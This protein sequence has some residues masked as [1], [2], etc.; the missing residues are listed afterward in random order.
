VREWL[1]LNRD[2]S[3]L[4]KSRR[5]NSNHASSHADGQA[6]DT[7]HLIGA[8]EGAAGVWPPKSRSDAAGRPGDR[9][10]RKRSSLIGWSS[11]GSNQ[12]VLGS[13]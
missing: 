11:G 2:A 10:F 8:D 3:E 1:R 12:G 13:W 7:C 5:A 4:G 6:A 9:T